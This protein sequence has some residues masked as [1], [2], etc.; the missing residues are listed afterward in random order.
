MAELG[1]DLG[2]VGFQAFFEGVLVGRKYTLVLCSML[3]IEK[4]HSALSGSNLFL[5]AD[6]TTDT[7]LSGRIVPQS[8]SDLNTIGKLF[9]QFLAGNNQTLTAKGDSV[10][11]AGSSQPVDWLSEAFK[12]LS[13]NV[14]LPG[15]KLQVGLC[16]QEVV[17]NSPTNI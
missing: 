1:I 10:Q 7:L 2:V 9:S 3:E 5:A 4:F 12:T 16:L 13:L 15:Q 6:S 14:I 8:G 11:P 17:G